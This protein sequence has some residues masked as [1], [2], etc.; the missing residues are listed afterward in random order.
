M[1]NLFVFYSLTT[2]P[3]FQDVTKAEL[4]RVFASIHLEQISS[5][6]QQAHHN[7]SDS[8]VYHTYS[9]FASFIETL[10]INRFVCVAC[11]GF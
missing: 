5:S 9:Y 3:H 10:F 1:F 6:V 7:D 4:A 8:K 11:V 2:R